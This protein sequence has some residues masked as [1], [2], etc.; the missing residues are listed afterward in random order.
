MRLLGMFDFTQVYS[1]NSAQTPMHDDA[2]LHNDPPEQVDP[3]S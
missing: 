1:T 2:I 3:V